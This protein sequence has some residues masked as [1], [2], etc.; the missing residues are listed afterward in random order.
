MVGGGNN[1]GDVDSNL[2][3]VLPKNL[4]WSGAQHIDKGTS[5]FLRFLVMRLQAEKGIDSVEGRW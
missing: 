1:D 4:L 2:I 5:G 3:R